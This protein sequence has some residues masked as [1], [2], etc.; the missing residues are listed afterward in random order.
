MFRH[1]PAFL[2]GICLSAIA[3]GSSGNFFQVLYDTSTPVNERF[4]A[5]FGYA[6]YLEFQGKKVLLDT[7]TD[8]KVLAKNIA[9]AGVDLSRLD[10]VVM[11]HDHHDHTGGLTW[12]RQQNPKV[13]VYVP[14]G[15]SYP[16][17]DAVVVEQSLALTKD[18]LVIRGHTDVPT[19]GIY[20]DLSLAVRTGQGLYVLSSCSH[21]GVAGI[22]DR[23]QQAFGEKVTYF[24]GGAR[25]IFRE[26]QDTD[27]VVQALKARGVRQVSP[28]HCSLS[29][30]VEQRMRATLGESLVASRLGAKVALSA[31]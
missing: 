14:P 24:S 30:A 22:V 15:Q 11:T 10:A 28:S 21:S 9:A 18:L 17:H 26:P 16:V 13:P 23:A 2:L 5:D 19:A 27:Q 31:Q 25:L 4:Q 6:V 20:D 3:Y 1:A 29:H 12:V 7:G 8:A